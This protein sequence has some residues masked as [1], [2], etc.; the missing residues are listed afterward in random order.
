MPKRHHLL[1][2]LLEDYSPWLRTNFPPSSPEGRL[3][4]ELRSCSALH[5]DSQSSSTG[6][7]S[8]SV[9]CGNRCCPACGRKAAYRWAC[10]QRELLPRGV[11]YLQYVFKLPDVCTKLIRRAPA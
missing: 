3:I 9:S 11:P 8:W 5:W 7:Q 4:K 6:P 1:I 2:Q 10:R